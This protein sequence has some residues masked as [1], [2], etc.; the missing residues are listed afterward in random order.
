M[1]RKIRVISELE[2][3]LIDI[4]EHRRLVDQNSLLAFCIIRGYRRYSIVI[5]EN[6]IDCQHFNDILLGWKALLGKSLSEKLR[7]EHDFI[8][9]EYRN[10][11]YINHET[12]YN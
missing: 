2:D 3:V 6:L 8:Q 12:N 4:I 5:A 10:S 7:V 11:R 1:S 9:V